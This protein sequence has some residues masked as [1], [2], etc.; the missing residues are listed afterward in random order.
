[1]PKAK[2]TVSSPS[3][4]SV[5]NKDVGE[6]V[7]HNKEG[8]LA[9]DDLKSLIYLGCLT[10]SVTVGN[11]K[12]DV[13]TLTT[14]E[15]RDVMKR[16]MADGNATE[17]MLDIKPLTMAYATKTVNGVPLESLS[18]LPEDTP[19]TERRLDV[20]MQLQSVVIERLYQ[21]Y[22]NLV[23]RSSKEIGIEDLKG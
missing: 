23:T 5:E 14:A 2:A 7:E 8:L 22:D 1:M 3:Q 15:Q 13:S 16:I 19:P 6:Q 21:V 17:R 4:E 10:E 20:M 11:Y 12:F 18:S 9:L